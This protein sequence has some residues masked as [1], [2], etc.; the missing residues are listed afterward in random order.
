[1]PNRPSDDATTCKFFRKTEEEEEEEGERAVRNARNTRLRNSPRQTDN[2]NN[3]IFPGPLSGQ[4]AME[5]RARK[6]YYR[7]FLSHASS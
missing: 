3:G 4:F 2:E 1:M 6:Q 7:C 5:D